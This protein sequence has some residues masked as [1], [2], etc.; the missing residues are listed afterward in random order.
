VKVNSLFLDKLNEVEPL[1]EL[2]PLIRDDPDCADTKAFVERLW[3][4]FMPYAD[5]NFRSAIARSFHPRFWEMY[6]AFG[7]ATQGAKI[8]P[9]P[10]AAPD[11]SILGL[12]YP[13]WVEATAPAKGM[14]V[15]QV[16]EELL[17]IAGIA[18]N[19]PSE[20]LI[21]RY[22]ASIEEKFQKLLSYLEAGIVKDGDPYIIAINGRS[23]PFSR[24]EPPVPRILQALFPLGDPFVTIDRNTMRQVTSG[25]SY[26]AEIKKKSG[27]PVSTTVFLNP[28]YDRISAVLFCNSDVWNRPPID[29][30]IGLDFTLIH[31]PR[32]G[33]NAIPHQWLRCGRECWVLD[34]HV[35]INDWFK[36][37]ASQANT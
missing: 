35:V 14:G 3:T 29:T 36:E 15:D 20:A 23:L 34:D 21:L 32:A 37:R 28:K 26:R 25:Y 9:T 1:D 7:L 13:V 5:R 8:Q 30:D 12:G 31:N 27:A 6:L 19:I 10:H 33:Q 11:L 22:R 24:F 4:F 18:Q 2:Y 17:G 16:P